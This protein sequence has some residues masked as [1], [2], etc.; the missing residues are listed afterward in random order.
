MHLLF[1]VAEKPF[2]FRA[3]NA[4]VPDMPDCLELPALQKPP[5]GMVIEMKDERSIFDGVDQTPIKSG[6]S[7]QMPPFF[8][9]TSICHDAT[10]LTSAQFAPQSLGSD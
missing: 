10:G 7:R 2:E 5:N 6:R 4:L 9:P 1:D 8:L 3:G